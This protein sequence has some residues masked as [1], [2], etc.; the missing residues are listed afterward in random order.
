MTSQRY[1]IAGMDCAAEIEAL[2]QT[3]GRLPGVGDLEFNLLDGTMEVVGDGTR[4]GTEQVLEAVRRAGIEAQPCQPDERPDHGTP[5]A[6]AAWWRRRGAI[7]C[8]ASGG[9]LLAALA[10]HAWLHGSFLHALLGLGT[11]AAHRFPVLSRYGYA[12]AAVAGCWTILP[13]AWDALRR[14]RPDMNLLMILAVAGAMGIGEFRS[15]L[16]PVDKLQAIEA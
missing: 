1:R 6:G 7:L 4:P 3:V 16:L 14:A 13:R 10:T 9:L 8:L 11:D 15:D 12:A 5:P 2:R